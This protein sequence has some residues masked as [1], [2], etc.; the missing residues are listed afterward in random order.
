MV[1]KIWEG[2]VDV[3]ALD[4]MRGA[5]EDGLIL[6]FV[7]V[8]DIHVNPL[9]FFI[10]IAPVGAWDRIER[11]VKYDRGRDAKCN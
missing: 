7:D 4:L 1:E 11:S 10:H 5:K 3:L 9:S 8:S 2:T 6:S